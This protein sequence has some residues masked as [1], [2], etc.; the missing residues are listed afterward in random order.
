VLASFTGSQRFGFS[1]TIPAGSSM[2]EPGV[3]PSRPVTLSFRTFADAADQAGRSR[4]YGGIHF[5]AGDLDGRELGR[6]V[7]VTA[8]AKA[9]R[10]F[11]GTVVDPVG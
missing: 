5:E 2:I 1:V 9:E 11:N 3:V 10:Y 7:G 8:R 6:R 4:R